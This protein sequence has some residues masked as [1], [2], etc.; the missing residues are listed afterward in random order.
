MNKIGLFQI[1][2]L[3]QSKWRGYSRCHISF[4]T[5]W[6]SKFKEDFLFLSVVL[7][8]AFDVVDTAF[9][10]KDLGHRF[11]IPFMLDFEFSN[12]GSCTLLDEFLCSLP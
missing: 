5:E 10:C 7:S 1:I 6:T 11:P 9:T 8:E 12:S 4:G 3:D 2:D